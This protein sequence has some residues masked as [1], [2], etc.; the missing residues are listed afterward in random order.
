MP[1]LPPSSP[2]SDP[3]VLLNHLSSL[4]SPVSPY[5]IVFFASPDPDTGLP[6]CGDCRQAQP[7]L[8]KWVKE[9]N[10]GIVFVGGRDEWKTPSN[11]FRQAF[12]VQRIPTIIKLPSVGGGASFNYGAVKDAEKLVES[13]VLDEEK[14]KSFVGA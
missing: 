11:P 6:W 3:S 14:L 10:S 1:L 9:S 8:A 5:F 2:G 4:P 12:D 7:L 13:D